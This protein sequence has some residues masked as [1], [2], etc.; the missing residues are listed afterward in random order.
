VVALGAA[1]CPAL[2]QQTAAFGPPAVLDG[3]DPAIEGLGGVAVARDG[4]GGLVYRKDVGGVSH[5]FVSQLLYGTFRAPVQVDASLQGASTEPVIGAGPGGL[6][7][8]AFINGGQLYVVGSTAVPAQFSA[9]QALSSDAENPAISVTALGKAYL[10]FTSLA[11]GGSDVR[12]AYYYQGVWGVEST[13]LNA[14]P[15]DDAGVGTGAPAVIAAG[16][17]VGVVAWG[18]EGH[19]YVRRVWGLA[20]SVNYYQADLPSTGGWTETAAGAPSLSAGGDSSF[21][22][23][24]FQE[25][26]SGGG[27]EQQ[28]SLI[29][30]LRASQWDQLSFP[31]GLTTPGTSGSAQGRVSMSELGDGLATAAHTDTNQ[32]WAETLGTNGGAGPVM[33]IDSLQNFTAPYAVPITNGFASGLI[34]WQHDPGPLGSPDIRA[35]FFDGTSF[36]PESVIS[37]P[38]QGP[39]DAAAG[40]FAGAD[41][42]VDVALAWV[43]G[44]PSQR[45]IVVDQLYQP[46]GNFKPT[47][48]FFYARTLTPVLTW[49]APRELWGPLYEV[50]VDGVQVRQTSSTSVRVAPLS[51]GPHSWNVV[52]VNGA[53]LTGSMPPA[54][55][56][57]D[58]FAPTVSYR[59][60][61]KLLSGK[62]LHI[63]V[64][65]SDAPPGGTPA[66]GS[67]VAKVVVNWGD[68]FKYTITHGKY[69][70]Y[71]RPGR[72]RLTVTVTDKAGNRTKQT[73]VLRIKPKSQ[74]SK[75]K[76][77]PVKGQPQPSQ[78]KHRR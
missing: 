64:Q 6:L 33:R 13:S 49:S 15:S 36:G 27:Q 26:F 31:D 77:Q 68:G 67:G 21:V 76:P 58:T 53:G 54:G 4:T 14:N 52:A 66:Q 3:P 19:V 32:L 8:V 23:V 71:L 16:D 38:A 55:V 74:P 35:R 65:Y 40:L 73:T 57:V 50:S 78:G 63:K 2:A 46:P 29:R 17:G 37:Q 22:D 60:T 1:P 56:F 42:Q 69:H 28:R 62:E 45:E 24:A 44:A 30:R 41:F 25:T 70:R 12:A 39:T 34:A 48:P 18:E 47:Q 9:P 51:Q 43:Q 7:L 11:S 72:Y 75:G 61:G 10:A 59:L 5:V 20:P